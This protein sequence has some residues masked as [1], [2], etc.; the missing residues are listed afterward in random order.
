[1]MH[2]L[3]NSDGNLMLWRLQ[4]FPIK[5]VVLNSVVHEKLRRVAKSNLGYNSITTIRVFPWL[6]QIEYCLDPFVFEL[7]NDVMLLDKPVT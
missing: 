2:N 3:H 7:L 6:L 1:M 5:I 4:I